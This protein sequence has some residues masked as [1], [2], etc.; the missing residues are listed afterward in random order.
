MPHLA[1]LLERGFRGR[2]RSTVPPVTP[3]AWTAIA[4]GMGPGRT[5]VLGFRHLDLRRASGFDPRL[6]GS[7]DLRGRTLFEHAAH[8]GVALAAYPMTWPPLPID[9]GVVLSGWPRPETAEPPVWPPE[10]QARIAAQGP[11]GVEGPSSTR[12]TRDG[13]DDPEAAAEQLDSRTVA[14]AK[15]W[16]KE[17]HDRL[18]FVG[19]QGTDHLAHRFWGQPALEGCYER[20]DRW[21]GE[22]LTAAGPETACVI[23]SDHGFGP[24]P[25]HQVHLGRAL[26]AAGLLRWA[27]RAQGTGGVARTLRARLPTRTWKRVRGRLPPAIRRWGFEQAL[28]RDGLDATRTAVAR[29]SL[30]EGWE[31]LVVQ[32]QGRQRRGH[33]PPAQWELVRTRAREVVEALR[34]EGA[35]VV[36]RV[37]SREEV[38]SGPALPTLPDLIVELADGFTAGERLDPGPVVET[39]DRM[40]GAGS[41]RRHGIVAGGG[42]GLAAGT[43]PDVDPWDVLPTALAVLGVGVPEAVDGRPLGALL[44]VPVPALTP[45]RA[46]TSSV[47]APEGSPIGG[48][49]QSLRELGYL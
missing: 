21:L 44:T 11:W 1:A 17:R 13:R 39:V 38:W 20:F 41:H 10:E 46:A 19:L 14:V 47:R 36:K 22:L 23:V 35:R 49:E 29:V 34:F 48:L 8:V 18:V 30:Y 31:G 43:P 9:G 33:V 4:T 24:G 12:Y 32:V 15:R 3:A 7:A 27:P 37:W 6:A 26:G 40:A 25:T 5:G 42:P 28:A 45:R 16:L 2:L